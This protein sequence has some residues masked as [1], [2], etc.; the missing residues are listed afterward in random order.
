MTRTSPASATRRRRVRNPGSTTRRYAP[1]E[2]ELTGGTMGIIGFGGTGCA[3][4]RR[5]AAFGMNVRAVDPD[6]LPASAEVAEVESSDSLFRMLADADVVNVCCPLTEQTRGLIDAA[7]LTVMKPSAF[8]VNVTCGEVIVEADLV[9]AL[10]TGII[11]GAQSGASRQSAAGGSDR[12][13]ARLLG[14]PQKVNTQ[15]T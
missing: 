7:A 9:H 5:A 12:Q 11:R 3:M 2:I 4:T 15:E 13:T 10:E 1:A 8:L 6:Q 14:A